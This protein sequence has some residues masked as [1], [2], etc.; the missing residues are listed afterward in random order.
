MNKLDASLNMEQGGPLREVARRQ[1]YRAPRH[2]PVDSGRDPGRTMGTGEGGRLPYSSF[3]G[4]CASKVGEV[5]ST[6]TRTEMGIAIQRGTGDGLT[7]CT[8]HEG[9]KYVRCMGPLHG[10]FIGVQG[11]PLAAHRVGLHPGDR[12]PCGGCLPARRVVVAPVRRRRQRRQ[13][14]GAHRGDLPDPWRSHRSVL[15]GELPPRPAEASPRAVP[16]PILNRLHRDRPPDPGRFRHAGALGPWA[17][18]RAKHPPGWAG[19]KR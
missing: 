14:P 2:A 5:C 13:L 18:R 7:A 9:E 11:N 4:G 3:L 17:S 6:G 10:G 1:G 8:R 12:G 19:S 16:R 15:P